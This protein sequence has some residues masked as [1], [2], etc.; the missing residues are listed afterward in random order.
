MEHLRL[1][2][3]AELAD[4]VEEECAAF[5][6]LDLAR[7]LPRGGRVCAGEGAEELALEQ[8][9]GEGGAVDRDEGMALP[10]TALVDHSCDLALPGARLAGEQH[11]DVERRHQRHLLKESCEGG[12]A[13]DDLR[14][15]QR[16][17][18]PGGGVGDGSL[19][20]AGEDA[21]DERGEVER[22]RLGACPVVVGEV[23]VPRAILEVDD[24]ARL[25][26]PDRG[27]EDGLDPSAQDAL[28]A[29][30]ALVGHGGAGHDGRTRRHRLGDDPARDGGSYARD[31]LV[32]EPVG[33]RPAGGAALVVQLEIT[34][35]RLGY[36]DDEPESLAYER[37]R[38]LRSPQSEEAAIQVAFPSDSRELAL[39]RRHWPRT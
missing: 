10:R 26:V 36:L 11:V 2:R 31:L 1:R 38:V 24:A 37:L 5:G 29:R 4:L 34:M 16:L 12:A 6:A 25:V 13:P 21:V 22:E 14:G 15:T 35:A 3:G 19:A 17:A 18:E 33:E 20:I 23:P 30:E 32:R 28:T 27:A 9:V 8:C 7:D 39:V